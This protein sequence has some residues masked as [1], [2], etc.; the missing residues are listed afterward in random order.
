MP[1]K[2]LIADD[3][4]HIRRVVELKLQGAGYL[5]RTV[6]SGAEALQ[7]AKEFLPAL[8]V[9]DYK[10]P[11]EMTGVD[12]IRAL[13]ASVENAEVPI[14]LLTGSV[15]VLNDLDIMVRDVPR[16]TLLSKPFSPRLLL[17]RVQEI[18]ESA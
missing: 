14:I 10:M 6:G 5:V 8:I 17:K 1:V 2:I 11:G 4:P 13:R 9:T 12:L 7:A 3:E 18:L 15:A 16:V